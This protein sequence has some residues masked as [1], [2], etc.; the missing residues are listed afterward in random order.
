[1][2]TKQPFW[3]QRGPTQS[4]EDLPLITPT[5]LIQDMKLN[6]MATF[7]LRIQNMLTRYYSVEFEASI[8]Q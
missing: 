7:N 3:I 2:A 4:P 5:G 8:S 1:M 6:R